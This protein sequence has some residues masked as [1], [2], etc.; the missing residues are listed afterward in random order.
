MCGPLCEAALDLP[1]SAEILADLAK[2]NALLVPLDRRGQWYRYHRLFRDML[3]AQ[4]ER[5]EPGL[6]PALRRRAAAWC[7][8]HDLREAA[9]EYSIAAGDVE[10]AT[11]LVEELWLPTH[12]QGRTTT[13]QRWFRWLED[14]GGIEGYPLAAVWA[15]VLYALTGRPVEAERWADAVDRWQYGPAARPA[16]P[17]T[18]AYAVYMRAYLC[19][20]GVEQMRADADEAVR[21]FAA[22]NIL[23]PA[24]EGLQGLARLLSGDLDEADA[25]LEDSVR[26]AEQVGA[27]E[28]LAEV[29]SERALLAMG[30]GDWSRVDALV[31]QADTAL[32]RAGTESLLVFAVQARAALHRGDIP[33]ARRELVSAQRV[34]PVTTYA[35]PHLAV[36]ARIELAHVHLAV[37]DV[38]GARTLM[39]EIDEILK[40][41]PGLGTL[42]G[43]AEALRTRLTKERSPSAPGASAL[44]TAELRLLPL[45]ATHLSFP[46]IAAE[47]FLS[48]HTV[49]SQA[50]SI[51]RKL[52]AT[53]RTQAVTRSRE[54]TLLEG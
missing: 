54:L 42:T 19:R 5:Q 28:T 7:L 50:M 23:M 12:R 18:E 8:R 26:I 38:A 43:E 10:S 41:R 35:T 1:G 9:L 4:L 31:R 27:N 34:R 2:S 22:Q 36:Q 45:L 21:R 16:D 30:R 39:Q 14:Q 17:Y 15:T 33:A 6:I 29:L 20:H 44:T 49:K 3:L 47:L 52:G 46:E 40:W 24:A 51:Y 37:A 53:S 13:L 32:R 11:R 25:S 48:P